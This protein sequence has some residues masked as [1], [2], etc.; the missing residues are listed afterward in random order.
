[1]IKQY[2]MNLGSNDAEWNKIN[3]NLH[4]DMSLPIL[5]HYERELIDKIKYGEKFGD[6]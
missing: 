5:G 2:N 3:W 6:D 1:M 4:L